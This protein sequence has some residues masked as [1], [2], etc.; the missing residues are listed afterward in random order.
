MEKFSFFLVFFIFLLLCFSFTSV[1]Q[2]CRL[3]A[4][5][6]TLVV[7][8]VLLVSSLCRFHVRAL[9]LCSFQFLLVCHPSFR[10]T[11]HFLLVF[12][13][14]VVISI[15]VAFTYQN[16]NHNNA[17]FSVCPFLIHVSISWSFPCSC[18]F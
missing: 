14:F 1:I 7:S 5:V 4:H 16:N 15:I 11:F 8:I 17:R 9:P 3:H 2:F 18:R 6:V 10:G 12:K 13:F